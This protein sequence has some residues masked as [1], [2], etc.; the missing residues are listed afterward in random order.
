MTDSDTK[1]S[2]W[3]AKHLAFNSFSVSEERSDHHDH[4]QK[5]IYDSKKTFSEY[6]NNS[7]TACA[8][9]KQQKHM[10]NKNSRQ[11]ENVKMVDC[12]A[13]K[14]ERDALKKTDAYQ[15]VNS[16]LKKIMKEKIRDEILKK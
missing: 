13:V 11:I 4:S 3:T 7:K 16:A 5:S 9:E 8:R 6:L 2:L 1:L 10:K 15:T 12:R 14:W